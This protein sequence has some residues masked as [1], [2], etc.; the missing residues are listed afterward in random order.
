MDNNLGKIK[1]KIQ[2]KEIP[3]GTHIHLKDNSITEMIGDVG[4]DFVWLDM[5][6]WTD[7]NQKE[8]EIV[9][10]QTGI[11]LNPKV[12]IIQ[13]DEFPRGSEIDSI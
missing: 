6:I 13:E 11:L 10:Q 5:P 7:Q 8:M 1:N 4:F 2:K 3:I 12:S 9:Q